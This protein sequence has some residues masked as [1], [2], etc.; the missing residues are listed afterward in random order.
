MALRPASADDVLGRYEL[1][2]VLGRGQFGVVQ[3]AKVKATEELVAVKIIEKGRMEAE[4]LQSEIDCHSL[5]DHQNILK[6][7]EAIDLDDCVVIVME[8]AGGV[9]MCPL[10]AYMCHRGRLGW[11]GTSGLRQNR[12]TSTH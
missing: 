6:F 5:L 12:G 10:G 4:K 9:S 8:F 11:S 1:G 7:V 3:R 2:P